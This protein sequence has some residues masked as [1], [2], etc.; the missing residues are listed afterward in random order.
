MQSICNA[1]F[2]SFFSLNLLQ[3]LVIEAKQEMQISGDNTWET[4][5]VETILRIEILPENLGFKLRK[6]NK[7]FKF[8]QEISLSEK[9]STTVN[10]P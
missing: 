10:V 6:M 3:Q 8:Y 7:N 4:C 5:D 9:T 1:N 2:S